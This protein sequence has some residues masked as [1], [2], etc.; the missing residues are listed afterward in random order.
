MRQGKRVLAHLTVRGDTQRNRL[1]RCDWIQNADSFFDVVVVVYY[2]LPFTFGIFPVRPIMI[3]I[4]WLWASWR[5]RKPPQKAGNDSTWHHHLFFK[6]IGFWCR[7]V[8]FPIN[9]QL[10][11][12][13]QRTS[14]PIIKPKSRRKRNWCCLQVEIWPKMKV[15]RFLTIYRVIFLLLLKRYIADNNKYSTK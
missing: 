15:V 1:V 9:V 5:G 11:K 10:K 2:T 4:A 12:H 3:M 14:W 13:W 8:T 7:L 6:D